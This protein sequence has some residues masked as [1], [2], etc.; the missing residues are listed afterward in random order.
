[1]LHA[2]G[3]LSESWSESLPYLDLCYL[4]RGQYMHLCYQLHTSLHKEVSPLS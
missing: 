1:M 4:V 3:S 2:L